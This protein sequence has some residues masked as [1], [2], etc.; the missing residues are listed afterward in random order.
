MKNNL[1]TIIF[2]LFSSG[3]FA[4]G[5]YNNGGKIVIGSGVTMYVDGIGGNY[6]NETN[7]TNGSMDLSGTLDLAGNLTNNVAAA[8][9]FG[10]N[11]P[12]SLVAFIGTTPQT[13]GGTTIAVVTFPDLTINNSSGVILAK[14]AAVNGIMTFTS[15]LF[16]I[17]SS[18]FTFGLLSSVAGTPSATNMIVATGTGQVMR[19]WSA[20]GAFTFPVGDNNLPAEYSPVSLNFTSGTFAAGA[21]AGVNLVNAMYNIPSNTGSYLNR[22]W[23]VTQTGITAFTANAIFQYVPADVVGT[24]SSIYALMVNPTP[25]TTYGPANTTL[26][27]LSINGL[28]SFGTFTG[29]LGYKILSLK[30]FLEGFYAGGGLMNQVQ[31]A[32]GNQFTGT[33]VDQLTIEL[34]DPVTYLTTVFSVPNVNVSTTGLASINI[35]AAYGGSY[36]L[37]VRQRNSIG[38]VSAAPLSFTVP[39]ISYDF[40]TAATQAFGS[41]M[42]NL[43]PGVFGMYGGDVNQDGIIDL[44]D[45]ILVGN[46][47][48][49]A[50]S[51]FMPEDVN[52]DGIIDLTDLIIIANSS[53]Q[54]IGIVT[55]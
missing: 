23:N 54:A 11:G 53:A 14:N 3:I 16:D 17:G 1:L 26:H 10:T 12:A 18:N 30:L 6:R 25:I 29:G 13:I 36:Y 44:T 51:G 28:T 39:A 27:Q 42:K 7:V 38:I 34:H 32:L 50:A 46:Q 21:A 22:F 43:G 24:E 47:S 49:L 31:G 37:T 48:A 45:L 35:P 52:G 4:Q 2:L 41:N 40:S 55:P 33:T 8:D 5:V 9:L 15:G 19:N 20:P